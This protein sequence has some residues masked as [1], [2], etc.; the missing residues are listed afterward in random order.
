MVTLTLPKLALGAIGDAGA[1]GRPLPLSS[2]AQ[3]E[4]P[5]ARQL[6][7]R[8]PSAR[9][10]AVAGYEGGYDGMTPRSGSRAA[11]PSMPQGGS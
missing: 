10:A 7:A 11:Q 6:S 4:R 8:Q 9:T 5:S 2:G 1:P 3:G